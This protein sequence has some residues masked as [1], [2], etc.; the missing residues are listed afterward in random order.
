MRKARERDGNADG[1]RQEQNDGR[2]WRWECYVG[3]SRI[4]TAPVLSAQNRAGVTS[5]CHIPAIHLS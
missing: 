4:T 2:R 1:N 3:S 5:A